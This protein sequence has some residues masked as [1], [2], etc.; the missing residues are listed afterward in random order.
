MERIR[1]WFGGL[2][3]VKKVLAIACAVLLFV[4][5]SPLMVPLSGLALLVSLVVVLYKAFRQRPF[6]GPGIFLL[7]SLVAL[8]LA[9]GV[10]NALYGPSTD[11]TS[12]ETKPPKQAQTAPEPT[13]EKTEA[14]KA[15]PEKTKAE[16]TEKTEKAVAKPEPKPKPKPKPE[17]KPAPKPKPKPQPKPQPK[18]KSA[19]TYDAR[20]TVTRVVDGDTIYISPTVNGNDEIRLI[21]IDTP[22]THYPGKPV[23]PYGPE[24][25]DFATSTLEGKQV[26]IEVGEEST[27]Q[28]GR[29]LAYVYL[30]ENDMFNEDLVE[31]G[32]A[33]AYPYPPNTKYA[34][35]F[36]KDQETAKLAALGIWGLTLA[37][38]CQ[39]TD[40]GN[41]I[42]EGSAGCAPSSPAPVP[43]Q[44]TP[45]TTSPPVAD[46]SAPVPTGADGGYNCSDFS[47]QAEAQSYMQPGDPDGLDTNHNGQACEDSF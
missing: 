26:G 29:L 31:K 2:T 15:R 19:S 9:S 21:G 22:E 27:D 1:A 4:V 32:Y 36:T 25:S 3:T 11:Q 10:S 30:S 44:P 38:Q 46:P 39:L 42:G 17:P 35:R 40:R 13:T 14:T 41:G 16:K 12:K 7:C 8:V 45:A 23:Q 33:Q 5:I 6:R 43:A 47:S 18:Q 37:E 24:A 20:V 28:Y 34:S